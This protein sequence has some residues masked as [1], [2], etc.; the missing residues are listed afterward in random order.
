MEFKN[1]GKLVPVALIALMAASTWKLYSEASEQNNTY[2]QTLSEARAYAKDGIVTDALSSYSA[3]L[4]QYPTVEIYLEAGRMLMDHGMETEGVDWA[5]NVAELY[6]DDIDANEFLMQCYYDTE[7]Y[8][9]CFTLKETL[10]K[11][12]I[13]SDEIEKISEAI[14]YLYELDYSYFEE[15]SSYCGGYCAVKSDG[16]WGYVNETGGQTVSCR[17][18]MASPYGEGI[19]AVKEPEGEYYFIDEEGNKKKVLPEG[20]QCQEIGTMI[21]E[22]IPMK[23][24]NSYGYYDASFAYRFGKYRY[25]SAVNYGIG[26]VEK[27]EGQWYFVDQEGNQLNDEAWDEIDIDNRGS[28][29]RNERAFARKGAEWF[30]VDS[31]GKAVVQETY[32]DARLFLDDTYAAAVIDGKWGFIDKNGDVVVQPEF[33]DAHSFQNGLAA[34][35]VGNSWGYINMQGK[36]VIDAV[37]E[38]AGDFNS[39]GCAFVKNQGNWVLL[40]LYEYNH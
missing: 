27:E 30:L 15:V 9:D 20:V 31:S 28:A 32:A 37:F 11:R 26:A 7:D 19:A 4:S 6:P 34:V 35:K 38:D 1:Y 23:Q 36:L 33:D 13:T 2:Q 40:K 17:Y 3:A 12:Q 8:Q 5:E 24:E 14:Q 29:F 25:A 16:L 10:N 21:G 39:S 18:E 22:L